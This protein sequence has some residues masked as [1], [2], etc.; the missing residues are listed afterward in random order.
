VLEEE[1]AL[2]E[3]TKG[4]QIP[5]PKHKKASPGGNADCWPSKK[6]KGK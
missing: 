5:E 6:T 3:G 4:S 2:L 1:A